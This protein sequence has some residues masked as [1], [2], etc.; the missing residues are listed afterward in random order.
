MS[1]GTKI[2][3]IKDF[4]RK[5][6]SGEIDSDKSIQIVRELS[7]TAAFHADHNI[8]VDLKETILLAW[9][10]DEVMKIA[11]EF[12]KLM[13]SFTNKIATV[14][15]SDPDRV[16]MAKKLE[17]C[18]KQGD[19]QYKVFTDFEDAIAWLSDEIT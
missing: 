9:G 1:S 3:K 6:E 5:N 19:F 17:A 2:Y 16:S 10:M 14:V 4:I 12:V 15:P 13:P 11:M 8:L 7:A 18:M